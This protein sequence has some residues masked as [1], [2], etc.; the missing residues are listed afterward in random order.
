MKEV[1]ETQRKETLVASTKKLANEQQRTNHFLEEQCKMLQKRNELLEQ[2]LLKS[3]H[4]YK[5]SMLINIIA[6]SAAV[7]SLIATI[8]IA[9]LK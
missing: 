1:E 9:F 6:T 4:E 3:Y 5:K 2:E 7:G 8:L